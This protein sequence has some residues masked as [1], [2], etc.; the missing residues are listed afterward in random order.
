MQYLINQFGQYVGS[1]QGTTSEIIEQTPEDHT[2]TILAPPR[3]TDYWNGSNWVNIGSAPAWYFKFNYETKE[4]DDTRDLESVRQEK[5]NT[6]KRERNVAEFGGFTYEGMPF[7]SDQI[8]QGRLLAAFVVQ[9]PMTWT[10]ADDTVVQLT[11]EQVQ[12]AFIAMSEH[13]QNVHEKA[14]I[15]RIALNESKTIAEIEAVIFV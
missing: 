4:W 10:L 1:I 13:I 5:W 8:S 7:D 2:T 14:R 15:A 12:G 9:R 6:I 3:S 11:K